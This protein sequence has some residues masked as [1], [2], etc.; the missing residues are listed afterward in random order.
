MQLPRLACVGLVTDA[1]Y[2]QL[3][4]NG[5]ATIDLGFPVRN[6]HTPTEICDCNDL[7]DLTRLVLELVSSID[8]GFHLSRF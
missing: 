6:T 8:A 4:G 5:I 2:V 3:E 1:A 7:E